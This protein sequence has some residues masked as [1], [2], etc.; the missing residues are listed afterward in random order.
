MAT[1]IFKSQVLDALLSKS[2]SGV[3]SLV[4]LLQ[5]TLEAQYTV[6][7]RTEQYVSVS[8]ELAL[9]TPPTL[10]D[11]ILALNDTQA[12]SAPHC[13]LKHRRSE[14]TTQISSH[15]DWA[16]LHSCAADLAI[17][18]CLALPIT[19]NVESILGVVTLFNVAHT[20]LTE[21]QQK[22]IEIL[23]SAISQVLQQVASER[24]L[25]SLQDAHNAR[26]AEQRVELNESNLLLKKAIN[27]RNRIQEQLVEMESMAA[28]TTM[29][30]SLTHEMNT[31]LGAAITATSHLQELSAQSE[32]KFENSNLKKSDL[33]KLYQDTTDALAIVQRNVLRADQLM[34]NFEQLVKDQHHH[35]SREINLCH[36]MTE[37]L[38][39]LKPKLKTTQHRFCL[40][41]P[42][43]LTLVCHPGAIG[44][45][46]THLILNSIEH[47]FT[48]EQSGKISIQAYKTHV[49]SGASLTI[50]YSD[51]GQGMEPERVANL[52]KPFFSLVN[53]SSENG[54]GMHICY[55]IVVKLLKGTIDCH[56]STNNGVHFE[57]NFPLNTNPH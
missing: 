27:Q 11:A 2:S 43:D 10:I 5:E 57:I 51:N 12:K 45:V 50:I 42:S 33:K 37:V 21:Q 16:Q 46:L 53:G 3:S 34:R 19:D 35:T 32:A 38:L 14:L 30:S 24:H 55:N 6:L 20:E 4:I 15:A 13:V 39:S 29:L 9:T 26:A 17:E 44:Q 49:D 56:S 48:H 54:L 28:L 25:K 23:C 41:I 36:Y 31:P 47:A 18:N 7:W 40:D 1:D 8:V 52:Y 22:R